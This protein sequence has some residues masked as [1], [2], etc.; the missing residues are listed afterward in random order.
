MVVISC[1]KPRRRRGRAEPE[2][3]QKGWVGGEP[4][5]PWLSCGG[6]GVGGGGGSPRSNRGLG[7]ER[8]LTAVESQPAATTSHFSA[9]VANSRRNSNKSEERNEYFRPGA[10]FWLGAWAW[11]DVV[12]DLRASGH[13][14]YPLSLTGLADRT[15]L[16][17]PELTL[18]DHIN[19]IVNLIT[20]E[21]LHDVILVAHSGSGGTVTAA[22][23]RV[24]ERVARVV[25]V[26]SGPVPDGMA[27]IDLVGRE[28]VEAALA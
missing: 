14:A 22:A 19:D 3:K 5:V 20:F 15:H 8:G 17:S 23:G 9:R 13:V 16:L 27:Q 18:D 21:D 26:D 1:R 11:K 28:T 4:P 25:Y 2:V 7:N 12:D 24:P 6:H 10:G